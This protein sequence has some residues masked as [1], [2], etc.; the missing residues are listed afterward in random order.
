MTFAHPLRMARRALAAGLPAACLMLAL[1]A[2]AAPGRAAVPAGSYCVSGE[3]SSGVADGWIDVVDPNAAAGARVTNVTL[4]VSPA[5]Y[6]LWDCAVDP[7]TGDIIVVDTGAAGVTSGT[8]DGGVFRIAY[9]EG[10]GA[11]TVTE[12]V[13]PSVPPAGYW[14][15]SPVASPSN[16]LINPVGVA[17][18][19][20]GTVYIADLGDSG[21][22][23]P[24]DGAIYALTFDA[25][26]DVDTLYRRTVAGAALAN[27]PTNVDIDPRPFTA[28]PTGV[29]LVFIELDG[30]VHR[31]SADPTGS[32][33]IVF[34]SNNL[35]NSDYFGIE[36]GPYG[37]Y[38][39][40][41]EDQLE[42]YVRNQSSRST[43]FGARAQ[44]RL[45]SLT[46][47]YQTGDPIYVD[48][49]QVDTQGGDPVGGVIQVPAN[50]DD[51]GLPET[52]IATPSSLGLSDALGGTVASGIG[53]STHRATGEPSANFGMP[54]RL[55]PI[56]GSALVVAG[57]SQG[58]ASG[59]P[60]YEFNAFIEV[61][62]DTG[63]LEVR[64]F[65]PESVGSY[66]WN[67]AGG[68]NS[69]V[70]VEL[71]GPGGGLVASESIAAGG[72][73]DLNQRIATLTCATIPCTNALVL[74][75]AGLDLSD[76]AMGA[77]LYRLRVVLS[78][79]DMDTFGVWVE[80]F[81]AYTYYAPYAALADLAGAPELTPLDAQRIYPYFDRGCEYALSEFD[82]D[83]SINGNGQLSLLL[84]T[85][86]DQTLQVDGLSGNDVHDEVLVDVIEPPTP[87]W[88]LPAGGACTGSNCA[89][90]YGIH[91]LAA[92][93]WTFD[94]VDNVVNFRAADFN[95][96]EDGGGAGVPNPAPRGNAVPPASPPPDTP[97]FRT[98][99]EPAY[100]QA[101]GANA[102][103]FLRLYFPL[104]EERPNG[105]DW[106]D[107][108][109]AA[110]PNQ[111]YLMQSATQLEEPSGGS[112]P[113]APSAGSTTPFVVNVSV[114]NPDPVNAMS[115]F[116]LTVPIPDGATELAYS[117][118]TGTG[119][120]CTYG[121]SGCNV[122][123]LDTP[124]NG[125]PAGVITVSISSIPPTTDP[126]APSAA[127][128]S[129]QLDVTPSSSTQVVWLTEGPEFKNSGALPGN[130]GSGTTYTWPLNPAPDPPVG[131]DPH[132]TRAVFDA[133]WG[134]TES[135]G[136]LCD[137][138]VQEGS[139][140]PNAVDLASFDA[141]A[142]DGEVLVTWET[143]AEFDNLGFH[144]YRRLAGEEDLTRITASLVLGQGSSDFTARYAVLDP[145]VPNG[146][147]AEYVLEDI[148][149]DGDSYLHG[150][151]LATPQGG[152]APLAPDPL[153]Y[154]AYATADPAGAAAAPPEADEAPQAEPGSFRVVERDARSLLVEIL[155][156][157]AELT[158]VDDGVPWTQVR[159]P[160]YAASPTPGEP[161]LP[162]RTFWIE[163]L[164][165]VGTSVEVLE[166]DVETYALAAPVLPA[167]TPSLDGDE[168]HALRQPSPEAYA[169]PHPQP[170]QVGEIAGSVE[171]AGGERL[172]ALRI[173]PAR[174]VAP[175][176]ELETTRRLLL[177]IELSGPE[178]L[179]PGVDDSARAENRRAVAARPAVK[180][181]TRGAGFVEVAA[182]ALF[183]AGLDTGADPRHLHLFRDGIEVAMQVEGDADGRLDAGDALVFWADG[184][185]TR[186][187]DEEIFYV[188]SG[189]TPGRRIASRDGAPFGATA[190]STVAARA[191][192]EPQ[193][194][195][196]PSILNGEGDNFVGPFVFSEPVEHSVPT[197]AAS[198]GEAL[199]RVRLRG[200]TSFDEPEPDHHFSVR[201]DGLEA[202]DALFDGAELFEASQVLP[203]GL[204]DGD[205]TDVEVAPLFDG[206]MPHLDLVYIDAF[207]IFYRRDLALTAADGGRLTFVAEADGHH[208]V[209]VPG[210][211]P[212]E[213]A[214]VW[215]VSEPDRPVELTGVTRDGGALHFEG[216][217]GARYAIATD[218]GHHAPEAVWSNAPS[219]LLEEPGAEWLAIAHGSLLEGAERL[220]EL[221]R[222][223]GLSA[224]VVDVEDVYDEISGGV[225][226]PLAL[227][228]FLRTATARWSTPPRYVVF[229]GD[230]TYDYRDHLGGSAANLVPTMLVDTTFV[231]AAS[232]A[233]LATLDD[234][235]EAPDVA[236][237]RIPART[238]EELEA[239]V[240]KIARYESTLG[241]GE[242]WQARLLLV[243]DDG[244]REG[245][246]AEA[247][248]FEA[249]LDA[250]AAEFPPGAEAEMLRLRDVA[251]GPDQ[252]AEANARVMQAL[253]DGV[254]V[255][256]Y[257]GHGGPR[258]WADELVWTADDV[259]ALENGAHLPLIVTLDC[260]NGFFD[261]PNQDSL[262]EVALRSPDRGAV[263]YVS[264]T[265][266]TGLAGQEAFA[267]ALAERLASGTRRAGDAMLLAEQAVAGLAGTEDVLRS[268]VLIGDPATRLA[269]A[270]PPRGLF[271]CAGDARVRL[272]GFELVYLALPLV[273]NAAR[274]QLR[275]RRR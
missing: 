25:A 93:L 200:G 48:R 195:Y 40:S 131:S 90:D 120:T 275:R 123:A 31:V 22:G 115:N 65:D 160:G 261:A 54:T 43:L 133:A 141:V 16:P 209:D 204:V 41:A 254:A 72:R 92:N 228:D 263:A 44:A 161:E 68:F 99:P 109:G 1:L 135:L 82:R 124:F 194:A 145:D 158:I 76:P 177:R 62:R 239:V 17:V 52:R 14:D 211:A 128:L 11:G 110:P 67:S 26:G 80:D 182:D 212:D 18:G 168:I 246:A 111:P 134:R 28:A 104:Y 3:G 152:L 73:T 140:V 147:T 231:E 127:T 39:I 155:V 5:L 217:A 137:L 100:P 15:G 252:G 129:Y 61:T 227:R 191:I 55:A 27:D 60:E 235:D 118:D 176:L 248:R 87:R 132:G 74:R 172:L 264:S 251:E 186:Y 86:L 170:A 173:H 6:D 2:A 237:G 49:T 201:V 63:N 185:D 163:G 236:F 151:V 245:D 19:P 96:Y 46:I 197:P 105:L 146:V 9:D 214:R 260:L 234:A 148:E 121:V 250:V 224:L 269:L 107:P 220:A 240:E 192:L 51:T 70:D 256:F 203:P 13:G 143:A 88:T 114:V 218:E 7:T 268:W 223:E 179:E 198:G 164:D 125:G 139:I 112:P 258:V 42:R 178:P 188:V 58:T 156:P 102:N 205:T 117:T 213:V 271:G 270:E 253:D 171:L 94:G 272:S 233:A 219:R 238:P 202:I 199:L 98:S 180:I 126:A 150:P 78:Q 144:L 116:D 33:A 169:W 206:S 265:T 262:S 181:A 122:T 226:T 29:N 166:H 207:E 4:P 50:V 189:D 66:D 193:S 241:A 255:A 243:A 38:F 24:V 75:G 113:P 162:V 167:A 154:A 230:T 225:M 71:Y 242:P 101:Y 21:G 30:D 157:P 20:D 83:D 32:R 229:V 85:R 247:D 53:Y 106:T 142:G 222:A 45:R 119:V 81:H 175:D 89:L 190:P 35:A 136:P 79:D 208:V 59:E 215:D 165:T 23:A 274:R 216:V 64:L 183:A 8:V 267:R 57:P 37:N 210:L 153:A 84:R 249:L 12:L 184:V 77:G 36:V 10:T 232:D 47:D 159:V 149:L 187:G 138:S 257:A 91:N 244:L 69:A 174:T 56:P 108:D 34:L 196:L 259:A 266:V 221:R 103:T 95:G 130:G 97:S 273:V